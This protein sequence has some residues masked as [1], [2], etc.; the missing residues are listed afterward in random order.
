MRNWTGQIGMQ[1]DLG[2]WP[3]N[4]SSHDVIVDYCPF[5]LELVSKNPELLVTF[6]RTAGWPFE[7]VWGGVTTTIRGRVTVRAANIGRPLDI[8]DRRG[9]YGQLP[10]APIWSGLAINTLF[11]GTIAWGLLFLPGTVRRWRRRRGGRCRE[12]GY[13]RARLAAGAACPECGSP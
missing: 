1:E 11:Y 13:D 2:P 7:C 5:P 3:E 12:C 10:I 6:I 4:V 8:D 9:V